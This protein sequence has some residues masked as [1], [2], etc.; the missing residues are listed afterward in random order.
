MRMVQT[1]SVMETAPLQIVPPIKPSS[2]PRLATIRE[3]RGEGFEDRSKVQ[4]PIVAEVQSP[5]GSGARG[6]ARGGGASGGCWM[7][8][9]MGD[10]DG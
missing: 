8:M 6:A 2:A 7:W 5:T 3:E 4:P 10:W 1:K 9:T